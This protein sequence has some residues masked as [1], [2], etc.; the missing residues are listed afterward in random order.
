[1]WSARL[2][3]GVTRRREST[4]G[5]LP[6]ADPW[7]EASADQGQWKPLV[8]N[9]HRLES[10]AT[11]IPV[12][13]ARGPTTTQYFNDCPVSRNHPE[14]PGTHRTHNR[15]MFA[16]RRRGPARDIRPEKRGATTGGL[17]NGPRRSL[18]V[19]SG[20]WNA[21]GAPSRCKR[22]RLLR[23]TRLPSTSPGNGVRRQPSMSGFGQRH[24]AVS[25]SLIRFIYWPN[26][27]ATRIQKWPLFHTDRLFA[28]YRE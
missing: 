20:N 4:Q 27:R 22:G 21:W 17:C 15:W 1:M 26:I 11:R 14:R 8:A 12:L 10:H 2:C 7:S 25:P 28:A 6:L 16:P 18:G 19:S 24:Y 13:D 9:A 3:G 5:F 23:A